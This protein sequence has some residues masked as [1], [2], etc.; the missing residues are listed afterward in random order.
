MG[1][2]RNR[3]SYCRVLQL[4]IRSLTLCRLRRRTFLSPSAG[5]K[6]SAISITLVNNAGF[7]AAIFFVGS[8]KT[9]MVKH[10]TTN[11]RHPRP[12]SLSDFVAELHALQA[13]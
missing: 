1:V 6:Q 2:A 13:C 10:N 12:R 9:T 8:P 11:K 4:N 5:P 3:Y 7:C